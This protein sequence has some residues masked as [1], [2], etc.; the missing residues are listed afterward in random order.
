LWPW[1]QVSEQENEK[2]KNDA[3][4]WLKNEEPVNDNTD[5]VGEADDNDWNAEVMSMHVKVKKIKLVSKKMKKEKMTHWVGWK[6]R[7]R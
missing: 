3:L 7:N 5:N 6:M 4:S 1:N 2:R